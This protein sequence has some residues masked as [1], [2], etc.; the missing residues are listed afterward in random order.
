[1]L[2][3]LSALLDR[4]NSTYRD[5]SLFDRLKARLLA[6]IALVVLVY[7]PLNIAKNAWLQPTVPVARTVLN[8]IVWTAGLACL[9]A[10]MKGRLERAGN[11]LAL[12]MAIA[13]HGMVLLVGA[14][15]TPVQPLSIGIQTFAF[16]LVI[17]LVA[18]VF[19]SRLV[20]TVVLAIMV[21]GQVGF[22]FFL[23]HSPN[24]DAAGRI[25][26]DTLLREG[27]L[28]KGLI[29]VLGITLV[30]MIDAAHRHGEETLRRSITV[31]ENLE[32][33]E[34]ETRILSER[35]REFLEAQREFISMVSH[36]FR[37][38]LTT[39]QGAQY[40]L[41]GLLVKSGI[42]SG[43]VAEKTGR[44]LGLQ[45]SGLA[46]L[47]KLVDQVLMLNRTEH[48]TGKASFEL[49][50]PGSVIAET[51]GRFNDS[52]ET[53]RVVLRDDLPSGFTSSM[54][55]GLVKAATENLIANGL[56][57]S[58]PEKLVR[59]RV[60]GE[61]QGWALEVVDQGRGIPAKDQASVFEPFFRAGNVGNV[62]GTGLGLSIVRRVVDFHRGRIEFE[63]RE[64]TGTRFVIHFPNASLPLPEAAAQGKGAL[65][66]SG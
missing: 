52:M 65:V 47:S 34:R 9:R 44:W 26:A 51:V 36:E 23:L 56:K 54:D 58:Q 59:V 63:S 31:N 50:S 35:R 60:F 28:A 22:Y 17:L 45:S 24:L 48:I 40:L 11:G 6:T 19:A 14:T 42:L 21:A 8:L 32:R 2:R 43:S 38:P 16:D 5:R 61:P 33:L 18:I 7:M 13:V 1:M 29:F 62:S 37:T 64:N 55:P 12:A 15:A 46:T 4:L 10:V 39:V 66:R 53:A 27:M 3:H 49:Q 57:Y 41:D 30:R 25:S 20:A